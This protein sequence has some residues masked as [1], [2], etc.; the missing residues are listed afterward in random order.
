MSNRTLSLIAGFSYWI[1]FFAAIFGNFM[2]LE[3]IKADPVGTI[4]G[5]YMMV[6]AGILAFL[7]TVVFDVVVAWALHV[8][9][10]NHPL[11][12]PSLLFRMMHA[13]IMAVAVFALPMALKQTS[14]E[15]ILHQAELFDTIW[16]I[17][18]F[19][20]GIHLVLLGRILRRP[21]LIAVFLSIAG[22]MY[23]VDTAAHFVLPDY[24]PYAEIFLMLVAVPSIF[25]EMALAVWL[26]LRGGRE[27]QRTASQTV[28]SGH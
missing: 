2:V 14:V 9:F 19:F 24:D 27:G 8:L 20:F 25:G 5:Q 15:G 12:L 10:K 11:S 4:T 17:G 22:I 18:L 26:L 7:V 13:T 28:S 1:I 21:R 23:A 6:R 3:R 16:L